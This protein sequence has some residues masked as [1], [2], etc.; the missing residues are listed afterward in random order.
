MLEQDFEKLMAAYLEEELDEAGLARL[1]DAVR[2]VPARRRRFQRELRLHTLMRES[3]MVMVAR[4]KE[5]PSR[6]EVVSWR[7]WSGIAA[8]AACLVLGGLAVLAG[9]NFM[10]QPERIG[11]VVELFGS[12]G[13]ILWRQGRQVVVRPDTVLRAGDRLTT[14]FEAQTVLQLAG[15]GKLTL[16]GRNTVDLFS[17]TNQVAVFI[18]QGQVLMEATQRKPGQPPLLIRTPRAMV[19]VVGTVFG[20]EVEPTATR[21]QVHE[22]Q[23]AFAEPSSGRTV[24]VAAGEYSVTGGANLEVL[25]QTTLR[26]DLLLPGQT[27]LL[28]ADNACLEN[29]RS[30]PGLYLKV[31][32]QRR[33]AFL[34]F[35]IEEAG[36]ILSA[37]L[38][39]TQM[40]DP[41]SGTLEF[42]EGSHSNWSRATIS[43]AKAPQPV[44][45]IASRTGRVVRNQSIDVDVSGL[46]R[47]GGTYT[48]IMTLNAPAAADD[49]WF[50][51][52]ESLHPPQLI[53]TREP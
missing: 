12:D 29:G 24:Q 40:V 46:I 22:G 38:R 4:E 10:S 36:E 48:L 33:I 17:P 25:D 30:V 7:R 6:I 52:R 34:K 15:A 45:R 47:Q 1:R 39:L 18:E 8:L 44:R 3:A 51:S 16:Q 2:Q 32:G 19:E 41:G 14:D 20:L 28:P 42:W 49:I 27:R 9:W 35:H 53:L 11:R 37:R 21:V 31:E 13:A 26:P 43:G 23:V 5:G 50:G